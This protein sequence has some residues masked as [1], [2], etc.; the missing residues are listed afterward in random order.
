[1]NRLGTKES[2]IGSNRD[3]NR[4]IDSVNKKFKLVGEPWCAMTISDMLKSGKAIYPTIWSAMALSFK[5]VKV[6]YTM[7]QISNNEYI[8][9]AGDIVVY[10]Y[11]SGRGHVDFVV[12]FTDDE[13]VLVGGNRGNAISLFKASTNKLILNKAKW[14]VD[15]TG[16]YDYEIAQQ[17]VKFRF[18]TMRATV[19]HSKFHNRR[20]AN[21]DLY[22]STKITAASNFYPIGSTVTVVNPINNREIDVPITDRMN[23]SYFSDRIDLS[24][25]AYTTL[26][27]RRN[28]I[29]KY[30]VE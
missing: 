12:S 1:M 14:V 30:E 7:K 23:K 20:M 28:V 4:Y 19:Y 16:N 13:L 3:G 18:D 26:G 2:P 25:K 22:D 17:E 10:D 29:V 15:V 21:G 27:V 24:K 9:K 8:P 5:N 11:G 6:K